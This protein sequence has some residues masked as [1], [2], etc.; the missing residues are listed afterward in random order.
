MMK[1]STAMTHAA[2][3]PQFLF[4]RVKPDNS[5]YDIDAML[6]EDNE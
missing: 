1:G 6:D 5:E 3:T 2:F 4:L